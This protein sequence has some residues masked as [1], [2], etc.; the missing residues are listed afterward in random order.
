M[1]EELNF[2]QNGIHSMD[3]AVKMKRGFVFCA[4]RDTFILP[5][6]WIILLSAQ[7]V[8]FLCTEQTRFHRFTA[9]KVIVEK[10]NFS[11]ASCTNIVSGWDLPGAA[12]TA[13]QLTF[14]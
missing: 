5:D 11:P 14:D 2:C 13:I 6:K 8:I 10:F 4:K 3:M 9:K 7:S 1:F 12:W